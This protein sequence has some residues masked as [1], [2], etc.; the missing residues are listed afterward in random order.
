MQPLSKE[1]FRFES[2]RIRTNWSMTLMIAVIHAQEWITLLYSSTFSQ[3]H[4]SV[5]VKSKAWV[6]IEVWV[7]QFTDWQWILE[8]VNSEQAQIVH[9]NAN[10]VKRCFPNW[11]TASTPNKQYTP[12]YWDEFL[13]FLTSRFPIRKVQ[14][15]VC[16]SSTYIRN[17]DEN[18][19]EYGTSTK[20]LVN[21]KRISFLKESLA[22]TSFPK[23]S[24]SEYHRVIKQIISRTS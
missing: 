16:W 7:T 10:K 13:A 22:R 24:Q 3:A 4:R 21:T 19:A 23:A 2:I 12:R 18:L 5:R 8:N 14:G 20:H 1:D 11:K 9:E 17:E 15:T 6:L